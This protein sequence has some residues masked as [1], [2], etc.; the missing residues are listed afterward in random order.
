MFAGGPDMPAKADGPPP[1]YGAGHSE[2]GLTVE[3]RVSPANAGE[4]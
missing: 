2:P 3:P 4:P 1:Q